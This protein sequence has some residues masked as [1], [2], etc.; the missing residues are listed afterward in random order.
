L[1]SKER[2]NGKGVNWVDN[3]VSRIWEELGLMIR[4]YYKRKLLSIK[5]TIR[6]TGQHSKP[7]T[8]V[9]SL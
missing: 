6:K 5:R 2:E 3:G 4:I 7:H 8:F 1:F 9:C